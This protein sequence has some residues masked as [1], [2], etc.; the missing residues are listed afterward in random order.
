M[1]GN[2]STRQV[3]VTKG[4][5]FAI[6]KKALLGKAARLVDTGAD[7]GRALANSR[8]FSRKRTARMLAIFPPKPPVKFPVSTVR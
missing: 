8:E 3:G 4:P 6:L 5:A 7:F 1:G 2:L